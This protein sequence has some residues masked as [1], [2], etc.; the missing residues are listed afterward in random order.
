MG[1]KDKMKG[2]QKM[3]EINLKY[4]GKYDDIIN[5]QHHVSKNTNKCR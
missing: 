3:E 2:K 1:I 4:T 5:M